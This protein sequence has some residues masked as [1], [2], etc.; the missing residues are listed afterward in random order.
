MCPPAPIVLRFAPRRPKRLQKHDLTV[1][2]V[3][4]T[5]SGR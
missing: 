3:E 4:I 5:R 1:F 2:L